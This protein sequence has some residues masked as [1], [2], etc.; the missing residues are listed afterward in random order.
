LSLS[1]L[2]QNSLGVIVGGL[3]SFAIVVATAVEIVDPASRV[4]AA[5][6]IALGV[7]LPG[8]MALAT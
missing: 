3:C 7:H 2:W 1:R 4:L 6:V 5:A 8:I